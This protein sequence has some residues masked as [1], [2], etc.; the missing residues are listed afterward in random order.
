M[1]N[2]NLIIRPLLDGKKFTW[3]SDVSVIFE[4]GKYYMFAQECS[5]KIGRYFYCVESNDL[6]NWA[7]PTVVSKLNDLIPVLSGEV[8]SKIY[9]A[10]DVFKYKDKFYII[11]TYYDIDDE[12][13]S[14]NNYIYS[15][16]QRKGHRTTIIL[17]SD[18]IN[19]N[20]RPIS[21]NCVSRLDM[22]SVPKYEDKLGHV[23]PAG[24]DAIDGSFYLDKNG[25]PWL[26]WSDES[27]NYTNGEGGRYLCAKLSD[28]LSQIISKPQQ[29]FW[30]KSVNGVSSCPDA[31]FIYQAKNGDLLCVWTTYDIPPEGKR[32]GPYCV[33]VSRKQ[34]AIDDESIQWKYEGYL[35]NTYDENM[36]VY[37]QA[38]IYND[39]KPYLATGGHANVF[40]AHDGQLYLT[41]HLNQRE[42]DYAGSGSLKNPV[43]IALKEKDNKLVWGLTE[44]DDK[45]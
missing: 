2:E 34:G 5:A 19:G 28:D 4:N 41:L 13:F 22:D 26:I 15:A 45:N 20:Y 8:Y 7:K 29:L 16:M 30:V 1:G 43:F 24:Q 23:T 33:M 31:G 40:K 32:F 11:G 39:G 18:T 9:W 44:K 14:P 25:E 17:C 3:A 35:Y 21:K 10:P 38:D 42:A 36:S 37:D 27:T 6:K 12:K